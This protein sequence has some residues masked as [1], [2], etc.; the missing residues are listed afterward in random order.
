MFFDSHAH[1]DTS[2]ADG[3]LPD[4]LARAAAAAVTRICA[5][6]SEPA[7]NRLCLSLAQDRPN[8]FVASVG[9]CCDLAGTSPD[10]ALLS[11][12]ADA[13]AVCAV[14][15]IG[16]DYYYNPG[17]AP[18]QRDLLARSLDFALSK[19]LPVIIHTRD[20]DDDTFSALRDF[21]AAWRALPPPTPSAAR[22]PPSDAALRSTVLRQ[23]ARVSP[24]L[25]PP[26]PGVIHCFTRSLDL[27]ERFVALGFLVSF[28]GILSFNNAAPLREAAARLPLESLLVETDSPYLA[29]KPYRGRVNEPAYVAR[30]AEVLAEAKQLPLPLVASAT[31]ANAC[32]LFQIPA[33]PGANERTNP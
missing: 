30:V 32:R 5:V 23:L 2:S 9:Y 27:A 18:A 4:V 20:A 26:P 19:R 28:S 15:E 13:P 24:P 22:I 8:L 31:F 29:P 10:W 33:P 6:G 14:G 12:L 11:D 7:S 3:T 1:F 25:P 16:L 21:A 17:N